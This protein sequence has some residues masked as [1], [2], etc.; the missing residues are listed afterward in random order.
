[1]LLVMPNLRA[2]DGTELAYRLI[3]E[4]APVI[5]LPGGPMRDSAYLGD[6]GGLGTL[7]TRSQLVVLDLRGTGRSAV[8]AD[9][10]SY[11]C[12]RLIGDVDA[13]ADHLG[14]GS[15]DLL[16]H[17]AGANI[18]VQYA[19]TR[20][21][22]MR[23]LVLITPSGRA[24]GINRT[25]EA[26]REVVNLRRHEPW[27]PDAAAALERIEADGGTEGDWRAVTPLSYGRWDAEVQAH[28]AA[29]DDQMN[30]EAAEIFGADGAFDPPAT[31]AAL[32]AFSRPVLL[33][34]G[35]LDAA[36]GPRLAAEFA[37]LF[38]QA[39]LVVQPGAGHYPWLDNANWFAS[40]VAKFL[41]DGR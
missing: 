9:T 14:L 36:T 37:A 17:S 2:I 38:P 5:C 29:Q 21:Q 40:A 20:P 25:S 23:K 12:D 24:V 4:G 10:A 16:G 7:L 33:L 3:G 35:E 6:L 32:A 18:A 27:F 11:R 26:R 28:D 19:A 31:R 22:R 39:K 1:M 15:F 13:L 34:A 41:Y 8:P 30:E